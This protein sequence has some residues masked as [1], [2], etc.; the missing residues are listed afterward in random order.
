MFLG[1]LLGAHCS[2][3]RSFFSSITLLHVLG[4]VMLSSCFP[5]ESLRLLQIA[6]VYC[7]FALLFTANR[8]RL[9]LTAA[10]GSCSPG[11][12]TQF[13]KRPRMSARKIASKHLNTDKDLCGDGTQ[14]RRRRLQSVCVQTNVSA[15]ESFSTCAKSD[16]G[17]ARLWKTGAEL[18]RR[19]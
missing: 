11:Q 12:L 7:T 2:V 19:I 8:G 6:G 9:I 4:L 15:A 16:Y 17:D 13:S 18:K 14:Q 5:L 1:V 10:L 3:P